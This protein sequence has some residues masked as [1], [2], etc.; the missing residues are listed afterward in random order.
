MQRHV[1]HALELYVRPTLRV[2]TTMRRVLTNHVYLVADCLVVNQDAIFHQ[3]P[4]FRFYPFIVVPDVAKCVGLGFICIEIDDFGIDPILNKSVRS[5]HRLLTD[6]MS[7][8][9]QASVV[10]TRKSYEPLM[11]A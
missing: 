1:W 10:H 11:R 7:K 6:Y 8:M 4:L 2:T 5:Y 9:G 3:V